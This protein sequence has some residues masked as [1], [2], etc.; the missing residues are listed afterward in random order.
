MNLCLDVLV[1]MYVC[2]YVCVCVDFSSRNWFFGL[3]VC[4]YVC[5]YVCDLCVCAHVCKC[6]HPA[7][8]T[9]ASM[10]TNEEYMHDCILWM[11]TCIYACIYIES[12]SHILYTHVHAYIHTYIHTYI[13]VQW[14]SRKRPIPDFS[15]ISCHT[16]SRN[17]RFAFIHACMYEY[18]YVCM[19]AR[20][21]VYVSI[22]HTSAAIQ[23]QDIEGLRLYMY[24]CMSICMYVRMYVCMCICMYVHMYV[25]M[26]MSQSAAIQTQDIEGSRLCMYVRTSICMYVCVYVC[27]CICMYVCVCPNFSHIQNKNL[28]YAYFMYT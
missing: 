22:L 18:M 1:C 25:C 28:V 16:N 2:M 13:H 8:W 9:H 19:Y 17:W 20:M 5:M 6:V 12:D 15:H 10:H 14:S 3:Y 4:M 27:M 7:S 21:Y 26:C 11:R 23:T 24:V